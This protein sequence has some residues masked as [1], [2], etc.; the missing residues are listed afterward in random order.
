MIPYNK[1]SFSLNNTD[2]KNIQDIID[3][4]WVSIG[5][6]VN[7]VEEYFKKKHNV[8]HAIACSCA[9]SGLIIAIKSAGWRDKKI[10]VPAFTW[11]STVYAID[12]NR[13]TPVFKDINPNTWSMEYAQ[14]NDHDCV[15]SVDVFGSESYIESDKPVIYDA[16]HGFSLPRLGRRGIAEVVSFSFTKR[17][18]GMEGGMILTNDNNL[19]E[20]AREL[21][22]LSSRMGEINAYIIL[23]SINDWG[24]HTD[25]IRVIINTYQ[26]ELNFPFIEQQK[27][28]SNLSV[29]AI[30]VEPHLKNS[31]TNAFIENGIEFK[32]YYE[33]LV[34]GLKHTDEL[35]SRIIA[36][37]AYPSL[38]S[39]DQKKICE[40]MN[41]AA[42]ENSPGV[43]YIRSNYLRKYIENNTD[44]A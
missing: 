25:Q 26:K 10:A 12:S 13:N 3:S 8:K 21:G 31:I 2:H 18:T 27:K 42:K 32:S 11:P 17:V 23:K 5:R 44:T 34:H 19:A 15:I 6:Y 33:P 9:T 20:C 29:Y 43:K 24:K 16:A 30:L 1:P 39:Y 41:A 4:G 28:V 38:T 37:P 7:E 35:Y 22:R 36:L 40:V 14:S